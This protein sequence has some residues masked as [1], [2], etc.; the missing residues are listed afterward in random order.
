MK[1]YSQSEGVGIVGSSILFNPNASSNTG[2]FN[3]GHN[4]HKLTLTNA[5]TLTLPVY[6]F[7]CQ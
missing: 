5:T 4:L 7:I 3:Q 2:A 6:P 1:L